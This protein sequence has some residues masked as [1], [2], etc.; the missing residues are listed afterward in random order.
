MKL[1]VDDI[2]AIIDQEID[3]YKNVD[4][5]SQEV[6]PDFYDGWLGALMSIKVN[7]E[8]AKEVTE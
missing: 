8:K 3:F 1:T 6:S 4:Y 2:F 7:L 5:V